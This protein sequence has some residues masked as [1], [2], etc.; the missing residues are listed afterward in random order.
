MRNW[1]VCTPHQLQFQTDWGKDNVRDLPRACPLSCPALIG[2]GN[3]GPVWPTEKPLAFL[4]SSPKRGSLGWTL[5]NLAKPQQDTERQLAGMIK[6]PSAGVWRE[7]LRQ[8]EQQQEAVPTTGLRW[9]SQDPGRA[10][11]SKQGSQRVSGTNTP[12]SLWWL[13]I[14]SWSFLFIQPKPKGRGQGALW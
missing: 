14:S 6:G 10:V 7:I 11:G 8:L 13:L 2:L 9:C 5:G 4:P 1:K 12:Y 3:L